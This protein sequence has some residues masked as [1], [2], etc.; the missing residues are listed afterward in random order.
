[1]TY[2]RAHHPLAYR[3][4]YMR[5]KVFHKE[6]ISF[7]YS[8]CKVHNKS[9]SYKLADEDDQVTC[10]NCLIKMVEQEEKEKKW[11]ES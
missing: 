9:A 2:C 11:R 5:D 7:G 1:M 8:L 4:K 3:T 6:S 10:I